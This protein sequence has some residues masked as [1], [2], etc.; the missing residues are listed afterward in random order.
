QNNNGYCV[1]WDGLC[2]IHPVKPRMCRAWPFIEGV[3]ADVANWHI[4]EQF[5]PGIRTD[6]PDDMI[7]QYV[8]DAIFEVSNK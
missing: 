8:R 7:V 1:F 4:M 3:L 6:M 2:V 5:C